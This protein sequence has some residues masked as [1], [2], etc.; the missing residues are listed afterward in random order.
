MVASLPSLP[1]A[2]CSFPCP[3]HPAP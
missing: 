1:P 3:L 2:P